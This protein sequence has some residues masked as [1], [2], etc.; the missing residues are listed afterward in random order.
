[1]TIQAGY[2]VDQTEFYGSLDLLLYLVEKNELD[3]NEISL[4]VIIDEYIDFIQ[5]HQQDTLENRSDFLAVAAELLQLKAGLLLSAGSGGP[6][7]EEQAEAEQS[8]L[9]LL[10]RILIYKQFCDLA[11]ELQQ[12]QTE[13]LVYHYARPAA[14]SSPREERLST[15]LLA[16]QRALLRLTAAP[17]GASWSYTL[18]FREFKLEDKITE[19]IEY[20]KVRPAGLSFSDLT[21][22]SRR[23]QELLTYFLGVLEL[24]RSGRVTVNQSDGRGEIL[25]KLRRG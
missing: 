10:T 12:R 21:R 6:G 25:I 11:A 19:T 13:P 22:H 16:L 17:P 5:K 9:E 23:V 15:S 14:E 1:M 18:P 8:E 20:L 7:G 24:V 3:L 2:L 4:S